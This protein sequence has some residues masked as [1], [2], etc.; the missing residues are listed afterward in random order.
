MDDL[1]VEDGLTLRFLR[2]PPIGVARDGEQGSKRRQSV[3]GGEQ[4]QVFEIRKV[5]DLGKDDGLTG[6]IEPAVSQRLQVVVAEDVGRRQST[7]AHRESPSLSVAVEPGDGAHN[8][9]QL[10]WY[11]WFVERC[12]ERSA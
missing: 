12:V 8:R 9:R 4:V 7:R 1:E 10:M 3:L 6:A 11:S 5:V 2:L